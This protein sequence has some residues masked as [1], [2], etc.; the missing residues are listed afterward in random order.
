MV[1]Q[2]PETQS[3]TESCEEGLVEKSVM[4]LPV[5]QISQVVLASEEL[6][7]PAWHVAQAIASLEV[8]GLASLLPAA[9]ERHVGDL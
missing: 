6:Y 4:V 5:G 3:S 7:S 8:D 2:E 1:K 9:Q